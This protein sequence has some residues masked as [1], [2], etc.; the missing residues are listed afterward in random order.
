MRRESTIANR[1]PLLNDDA[2]QKLPFLMAPEGGYV[3]V[4]TYGRSG[5]TLLQ[6][7][8][9]GIHGYCI[10][11][12][13][14]EVA[15]HLGSAWCAMKDFA[16][17]RGVRGKGD[18]TEP[19]H[20]WYGAELTD[21]NTFGRVL[22]DAFVR[23]ILKLPP[24]TRVGGFKEIRYLTPRREFIQQ[25][26]FLK[27][28]FPNPRF[29]FNTRDHEAVA[30][31]GWWSECDPAEVKETL[32]RAEDNWDIFIANNPACCLKLHYDDYIAHPEAFDAL[33]DFLGEDRDPALVAR[34]LGTR[35][36]HLK[37]TSTT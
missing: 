17:M 35:L 12:E 22:A 9:N 8:L 19:S 15:L 16:P 6:N 32:A 24:G 36:N 34:V 20:P 18:P 23:E 1:D 5:S 21:P 4:V 11:G 29:V 2:K 31:S 37:T 10:R 3:F 14:N 33:F 26:R 7:L 28:V 25:M 27:T 13:N 30:R